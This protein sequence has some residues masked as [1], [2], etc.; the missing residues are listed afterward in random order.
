[1]NKEFDCVRMK[2]KGAELVKKQ[3]RG[4]SKEEELKFWQGRTK[5]LLQKRK[6]SSR[7]SFN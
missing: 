6:S 7:A 2:H 4:M 5:N 3:I 1:M